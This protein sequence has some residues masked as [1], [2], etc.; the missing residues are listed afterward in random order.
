[1]KKESLTTRKVVNLADEKYSRMTED[2]LLAHV[3]DQLVTQ[4]SQLAVL[5][6]DVSNRLAVLE[7]RLG[8]LP[9]YSLRVPFLDEQ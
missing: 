3:I 4:T 1:M 9:P 6:T 8:S 5:I 7:D 2:E